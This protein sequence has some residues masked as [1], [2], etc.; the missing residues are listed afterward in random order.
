MV[1]CRDYLVTLELFQ[2]VE[3]ENCQL[4]FTNPRPSKQKIAAYYR[5]EDYLSHSD[6]KNNL[7]EKTYQHVK[8]LMLDRKLKMIGKHSKREGRKLLDFG[9]GTGDF[10]LA[11]EKKGYNAIGY[12]PGKNAASKAKAKGVRVF[13]R[14]EE[15]YETITQTK[16]D[17]ITLWHVL[18]HMHEYP[19]IIDTLNLLLNKN[20]ILVIAVPVSSSLDAKRYHKYWAAYDVP[21]HLFH[22]TPDTLVPAIVQKGFRFVGKNGLPFDSYY[23]SLLSEK[24]KKQDKA[25]NTGPK[26]TKIKPSLIDFIKATAIGSASNLSAMLQRTPWSGEVY[27]FEKTG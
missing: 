12:E 14:M 8:T 27:T 26:P 3:C 10:L 23:I 17:I 13:T 21:R 19:G 2:I 24:N 20:G 1:V 5:S 9:C 25:E 15:L 6:G 7:L 18:E 4:R 16:P 22:F 11:A